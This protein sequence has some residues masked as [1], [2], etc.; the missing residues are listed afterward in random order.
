MGSTSPVSAE[1]ELSYDDQ[2]KVKFFEDF[3][4][5]LVTE[6]SNNI[7]G[8][9]KVE[10][11]DDNELKNNTD[12]MFDLVKEVIARKFE[13]RRDNNDYM[14]DKV[15]EWMRMANESQIQNLRY[16]D[17]RS[18][19]K[20]EIMN[21][22]RGEMDKKGFQ[23]SEG[24]DESVNEVAEAIP[25]QH[26]VADK[27]MEQ[28]DQKKKDTT[29]FEGVRS[30][31]MGFLVAHLMEEYEIANERAARLQVQTYMMKNFGKPDSVTSEV[32]TIREAMG[33]ED[34]DDG[35]EDIFILR[36]LERH[37]D[38]IAQEIGVRKRSGN[39]NGAIEKAA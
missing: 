8:E 31:I 27:K 21:E 35:D 5:R 13:F 18:I 20:E 2:E 1:K 16:L 7:A 14:I 12:K 32:V 34:L 25:V 22:V 19:L 36:F 38:E 17:L 9:Y 26:A 24:V 10:G 6:I 39:E 15:N 29:F 11:V 4:S 23:K 30:E 37:A 3:K 28:L 33:K